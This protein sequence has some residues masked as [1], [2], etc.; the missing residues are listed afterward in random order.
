[1][2]KLFT[3]KLRSRILNLE[4]QVEGLLKDVASRDTTISELSSDLENI[5][6]I[7]DGLCLKLHKLEKPRVKRSPRVL[8]GRT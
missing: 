6:T 2:F 4:E 8:I 1:M 3:R 7:N 5:Q